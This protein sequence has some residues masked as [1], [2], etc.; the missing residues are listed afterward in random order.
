MTAHQGLRSSLNV[1]SWN[2]SASVCPERLLNQWRAELQR[3]DTFVC[4][5]HSYSI[6]HD[7]YERVKARESVQQT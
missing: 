5:R 4:H 6:S 7:S 2:P 3:D 1:F